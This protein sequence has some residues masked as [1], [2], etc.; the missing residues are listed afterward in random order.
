MALSFRT[1][2]RMW[3][4]MVALLS[5]ACISLALVLWAHGYSKSNNF[6][7]LIAIP[8]FACAGA[9]WTILKKKFCSSQMI[10]IEATWVFAL[11]PFQICKWEHRLLLGLFT[12]ESDG[13][14]HSRFSAVYQALLALVWTNAALIF[15]YAAGISFLALLTQLS[16]DPDIWSRDIDS[17]PC[18]FPFPTLIVYALPFTAKHFHMIPVEFQDPQHA[19]SAS[20]YCI[21]GCSCQTKPPESSDIPTPGGL[22]NIQNSTSY[23]GSTRSIIPIRVPT[24]KENATHITLNLRI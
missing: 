21:P 6:G 3:M 12:L 16:Y 9:I 2:R 13:A 20:E 17:S 14:R 7:A 15:V 4:G 11:L 5:L 1:A 8:S 22:F 19:P 10:C 23:V 18:P 24:A